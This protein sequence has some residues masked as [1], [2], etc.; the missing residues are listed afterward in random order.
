MLTN[1]NR[2]GSESIKVL[3]FSAERTVCSEIRVLKAA[4]IV[5]M[6][7]DK[8]RAVKAENWW[9]GSGCVADLYRCRS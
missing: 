2:L 6:L 1:W 3:S 8:G 9:S 5:R 7:P 4:N